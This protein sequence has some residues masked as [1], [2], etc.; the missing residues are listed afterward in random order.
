M[1]NLIALCFL[2]LLPES[3]CEGVQKVPAPTHEIGETIPADGFDN[4]IVAPLPSR[5]LGIFGENTGQI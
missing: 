4:G 5:L 2:M 3:D 1:E